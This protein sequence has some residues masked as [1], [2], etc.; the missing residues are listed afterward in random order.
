MRYVQIFP[1]KS[2]YGLNV[3]FTR[4]KKNETKNDINRRYHNRKIIKMDLWIENWLK[5]G[6]I[7]MVLIEGTIVRARIYH[8]KLRGCISRVL[9]D[10]LC[11]LYELDCIFFR[12]DWDSLYEM[13]QRSQYIFSFA[14]LWNFICLLEIWCNEMNSKSTFAHISRIEQD[15]V[16]FLY[17]R[18][19]LLL[20]TVYFLQDCRLVTSNEQH[21]NEPSVI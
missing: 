7:R 20:F 16:H 11:K 6:Y 3:I 2:I 9:R 15:F 21:T 4:T 5:T 19:S 13:S 12:F 18:M 1:L 17:E 10:L 8:W 14:H